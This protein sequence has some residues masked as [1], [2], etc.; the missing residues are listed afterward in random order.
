[1]ANTAGLGEPHAAGAAAA[2]DGQ[3]QVQQ[4]P[5]AFKDAV[6]ADAVPAR[7]P[8]AHGDVVSALPVRL[9]HGQPMRRYQGFW[10]FDSWARGV[11]AMHR[12][13]GLVPRAGDVVLAS[14]PKSGTTWLCALAF[15]AMARRACPPA[16]PDHPLRR[17]NPHDCVPLLETLFT[18]GRDTLLDQLPSPRIM[19]TH[20][21]LSLLPATVAGGNSSTKIIYICRDQK[22]R[23]ISTWHFRRRND[24]PDLSL[25]EAYDAVCDGTCFAGPVWDHIL[26]YWAASSADPSR[27]LFLRYEQVLRDPASALRRLARFVG[28]PFSEAEEEG[29]VVGEIV[30][31]CSL[32]SLRGQRGNAGGAMQATLMEFSH[33]SL[34]R[35]GV[36]GDWRNHLSAEMGERLDSIMREKLAGSGLTL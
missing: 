2:R 24:L 12:G 4:G 21:P 13:G 16:S 6:D 31:L 27:V 9:Y 17:L 14:L 35:K 19:S 22:D 20:M 29:G 18:V 10:V 36:A 3:V 25:Q 23:L 30:G 33:E 15:A 32:D 34:F 11:V 28:R 5:V 1:M 8:T 7:P 26:E